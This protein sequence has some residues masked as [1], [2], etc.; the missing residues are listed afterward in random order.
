MNRYLLEVGVEEFPSR[1]IASTK[2]QFAH[3]FRDL[4]TKEGLT[5]DQF[6]I[7]STPR[8]FTIWLENPKQEDQDQEEIV[9]GPAVKIAYD[10]AGNPSKALQGFMRSK[11]LEETDLFREQKGKE[12]YVFARIKKEALSVESI[13]AEVAPQVIRRISNPRSMRWGGK[14]LQFLRPIRW[15]LSLYNDRVL[16]FELEGIPVS[17]LTRGHRFLGKDSITVNHIE[18][19][20]KLLEENYVIVSEKERENRIIRGMNRLAREKGGHPM[21]DPVLLA[22][23][24]H[25]VEYPTPFLG[26]IPSEYLELPAQ[27]IITPMKDH[28]RYFPVLDDQGKLLPYFLSVRNGDEQGLEN[29]QEGNEKV[30]VPRL[31]DA[32]FFF[33]QDL[34]KS[35]EDYVQE[36]EGLTFH[37]KLGTMLDK[38]HRLEKLVA[39][40]STGLSLGQDTTDNVVRAAHLS[41]ADLV[42]KMV[43]EFTELQGVMGRI[44]AEKAGESPIV[45]Q[46]IEEQYM[47]VSSGAS[48]P[49]TTSGTIL[50]LADKIDLLAGMFAINVEVT[51]SQD[52]FGLR[53]AAIGVIDIMLKQKLH[54][55]LT[56][57]FR[58]ALLLYV[59]NRGLVFD[60]EE[61]MGRVEEFFGGRLRN[62]LLELGYR[63]DVV[64]SVIATKDKDLVSCFRRTKAVKE[65]LDQDENYQTTT[66]FLRVGN[67]AKNA[68]TTELSEDVL[69]EED[70]AF[71]ASFSQL[72]AAKEEIHR[73]H[74][75]E[76][77]EA[78]SRW[79]PQVN[80][81]M[82]S[83]MIM[84]ED[85]I[86][87]QARLALM[88][89][90]QEVITSLFLPDRIVREER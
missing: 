41:K 10:A 40:L 7:E 72:D 27:V 57:S 23:V 69:Q 60:Y 61:V 80:D 45:A 5:I 12:E 21:D 78:L 39:Q 35:P 33:D 43:V 74:Y 64:D 54:V 55:D 17:N 66:S 38:T 25:I 29:V 26:N 85:P 76:A 56:E 9:R 8:R 83:T 15:I 32:K 59:E 81:Y 82:D 75:Q 11:G 16:P 1:F 77:L 48:L 18:D 30:L 63:Y 70:K 44:Y 68:E 34:K 86:L 14:N 46:A 13:L 22:E 67:M 88:A 58:D 62:K 24:V 71:Y 49:Q 89:R 36:L 31:E 19:Y 4:L 65:F 52:P 2:E 3:L 51:G 50:S 73:G 87:R 84:V 79:M 42:T 37:E 47:P 20:E 28:Q 90:I 53:R 6:R